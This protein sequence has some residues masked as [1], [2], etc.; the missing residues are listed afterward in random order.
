MSLVCKRCGRAAGFTTMAGICL[1][2]HQATP[3]TTSPSDP[4]APDEIL[5]ATRVEVEHQ[6]RIRE[7]LL[8]VRGY[9]MATFAAMCGALIDIIVSLHPARI[10]VDI[11]AVGVWLYL[12]W[13]MFKRQ[14]ALEARH[15]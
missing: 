7:Q 15:R 12:T 5:E 1:S 13:L 8:V 3:F 14:R 9:W 6:E 11:V 10:G 2:C 4:D